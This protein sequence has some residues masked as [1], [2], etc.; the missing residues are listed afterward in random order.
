MSGHAEPLTASRLSRGGRQPRAAARMTSLQN[1]SAVN[2]RGMSAT[3]SG[4]LKRSAGTSL[5]NVAQPRKPGVGDDALL[6]ELRLGQVAARIL[7]DLAARDL[8]LEGALE[9]EHDV[10]EVDRLGVQLRRSARRRA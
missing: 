8:H 6:L 2:S 1:V 7:D 10:E 3:F 9:P 4:D 5:R